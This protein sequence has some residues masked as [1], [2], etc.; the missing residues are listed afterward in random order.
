MAPKFSLQTILDYHHSRVEILELELSQLLQAKNEALAA[1]DQ[2]FG[3]LD[4]LYQELTNF[5][6][7][8]MDLKVISQSRFNIKRTQSKIEKQK[9]Q[10]VK[11]DQSIN[12]KQKEII[13]ARQ[14]EAVFGKLKE[15]EKGRFEEKIKRQESTLQTDIYISQAYRQA[16]KNTAREEGSK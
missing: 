4:R 13:D 15:K 5:Q 6:T 3:D 1:L 9:E 8:E 12:V 11:I 10:L 2:L 16:I 14:D 7:G